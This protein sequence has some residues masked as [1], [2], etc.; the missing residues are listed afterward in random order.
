MGKYNKK[1]DGFMLAGTIMGVNGEW[2]I[3]KYHNRLKNGGLGKPRGKWCECISEAREYAQEN[4]HKW[5]QSTLYRMENT[6]PAE[7][8]GGIG[9]SGEWS[10]KYGTDNSVEKV[11]GENSGIE[12]HI[13]YGVNFG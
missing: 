5:V 10:R 8:L 4:R 7:E 3:W 2:F 13:Y 6:D 1:L 12:P 9:I 11:F